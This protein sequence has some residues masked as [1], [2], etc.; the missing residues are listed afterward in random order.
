[1]TSSQSSYLGGSGRFRPGLRGKWANHGRAITF[2]IGAGF[3]G[4]SQK[5]GRSVKLGVAT[6]TTRA[7][8]PFFN[9]DSALVVAAD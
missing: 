1:M 3:P 8:S 2:Y 7:L 9:G 6:V 5:V 4:T